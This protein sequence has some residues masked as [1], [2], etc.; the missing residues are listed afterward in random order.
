MNSGR[1]SI[2]ISNGEPDPELPHRMCFSPS[3]SRKA[4]VV[5]LML[6]G[7]PGCWWSTGSIERH[8]G[9]GAEGGRGGGGLFPKQGFSSLHC[10]IVGADSRSPS[11]QA[12]ALLRVKGC[13][14]P[15][16]EETFTAY[17]P[18]ALNTM[19]GVQSA[20][21]LVPLGRR[22]PLTLAQR[23]QRQ[24]GGTVWYPAMR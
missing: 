3:V 6:S 8:Q 21:I 5:L 1:H 9:G 24:R 10:D 13:M 22:Q 20:I 4:C 17:F 12:G 11:E 19:V 15:S 14:S 16:P 2:V 23:H 18:P 7:S